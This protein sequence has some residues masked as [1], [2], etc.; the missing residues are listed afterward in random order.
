MAVVFNDLPPGKYAAVAYIDLND[1][2]RF[3]IEESDLKSEPFSLA[4]LLG[5]P[6][7][8]AAANADLSGGEGSTDGATEL[9]A[10]IFD[11]E[12]GQVTLIV[13]DFESAESGD[14]KGAAEPAAAP[15]A[16]NK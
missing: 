9:P 3:D 5:P 1:N 2:G 13:F 12:T 16:T 11:L 4:R 15:K 8:S 10:G 7:Q 14:S 6:R